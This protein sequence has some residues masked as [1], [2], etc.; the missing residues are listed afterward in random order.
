[1]ALPTVREL[2]VTGVAG[3]VVRL[4]V[5]LRGDAGGLVR[6]LARDGRLVADTAGAAAGDGSLRLKLQR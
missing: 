4:R 5:R 6:V 2:A 3:N 1:M